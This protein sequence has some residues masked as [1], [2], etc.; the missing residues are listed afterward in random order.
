MIGVEA[1][2][3]VNRVGVRVRRA[4]VADFEGVA[5]LLAELGRPAITPENRGTTRGTWERHLARVETASIVAE[6]EGRIVGFLS[7]E[8][9]DRLNHASPEAW[10]PDFIVTERAR[11][12]GIGRAL[13]EA[14][15]REATDRKAHR[16]TL[17]S[18]HHRAR[19]HGVYLAAGMTDAG[20]CFTWTPPGR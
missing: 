14:A 11:G 15:F 10:I 1:V 18:G 19:A 13:L 20:K 8:F 2:G 3:A 12:Q 16:V 17:E 5:Q 7:L 9:R 4:T 6:Q